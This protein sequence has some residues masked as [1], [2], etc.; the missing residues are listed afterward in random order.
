[1][2][3][4]NFRLQSL[5]HLREALEKMQGANLGHAEKVEGA[6]RAS[7]EES[8]TRLSEIED[9]AIGSTDAPRA[10]GMWHA[11]GL[12]VEAARA[13]ADQAAAELRAAE[14]KRAIE[15]DRFT[16]ARGARRVLEKLRERREADWEVEAG[17]EERREMEEQVRNRLIQDGNES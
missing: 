13:Q 14:E 12:S 1:M 17:R 10:A 5:L 3:P 2:K 11:V 8:D 4:F 6:R 9:Q 15:L 16:E 7:A